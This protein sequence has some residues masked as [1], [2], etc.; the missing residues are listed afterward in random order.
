MTQQQKELVKN[1]WL[2]VRQYMQ[3]AGELFYNKLFTTA[4]E[5]QHMFQTPIPEQSKKLMQMLDYV[6]RK[7]D[8]VETIVGDITKMGTRHH[9]YGA[10]PAH[11]DVV[12]ACLLE[13]MAEV[14]HPFWDEEL[15]AAWTAAY[16][17][18][19]ATMMQAPQKTHAA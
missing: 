16:T 17:L 1:S 2:L 11:Y 7:L 4:P 13:T 19:A 9:Q 5:V 15:K 6:V 10:K 14:M 3:D 8:T 12:G 18:V